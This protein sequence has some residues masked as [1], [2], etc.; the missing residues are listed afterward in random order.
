MSSARYIYGCTTCSSSFNAALGRAV[1]I[2][3][4]VKFDVRTLI[5]RGKA[6][7]PQPVTG[8]VDNRGVLEIIASQTRDSTDVIKVFQPPPN[9]FAQ[10]PRF[11]PSSSDPAE[12]AGYLLSYM[13]DEAQL[14]S[15]GDPPPFCFSELWIIDAKNMTDVLAKVELPQRVPYGLHGTWFSEKQVLNQRPVE[16]VR[17]IKSNAAREDEEARSMKQRV[18]RRVIRGLVSTIGG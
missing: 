14:T 11:V 1:K 16:S 5:E 10:E 18:G 6:S 3:G 15:E 12:D 2:D 7:P 17:M 4:L 13:F 9:V 8:S